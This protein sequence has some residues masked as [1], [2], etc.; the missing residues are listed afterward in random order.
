MGEE[1][2][3]IREGVLC[4]KKKKITKP[5]VGLI[6]GSGLG[7]LAHEVEKK[8]T[9]PYEEV[10]HLP[11]STVPGH[12]GQFVFGFLNNVP[13][14]I[15][16]GRYHYYEGYSPMELVRPLRILAQ[17]GIEVLIVTNAAGAVNTNFNVG[18]FMFI[19][20]HINF[21]GINPL[22][23]EN[24]DDLGPRFPDMSHAYDPQLIE[25]GETVAKSI[26]KIT[27]RGVYTSFA[28]PCFETP[29]EIKMVGRWGADAVGMST[30]PE[31]IA[32]RHMGLK[33][34]GISCITNMAAG[35]LPEPLSHE[36]VMEVGEKV[37]PDFKKLIKGILAEG[38]F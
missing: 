26:G 20:D 10:S 13:V 31:V 35:T 1:M 34:L 9:V 6:L 7:E 22:R 29:A 15:M 23:G 32:A 5:K 16:Q 14:A 30:V 11:P 19:S 17:M 18:D 3:K 24:L 33:V 4:L 28:G 36:E 38:V 37:K 27:R 12:S 2:R 21:M 8:K 25:V